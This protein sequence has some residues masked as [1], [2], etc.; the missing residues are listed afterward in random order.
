M[1]IG[2]FC[3]SCFDD[4]LLVQYSLATYIPSSHMSIKLGIETAV[5]PRSPELSVR[6]RG[7]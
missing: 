6:D 7:R 3:F 1:A 4:W 5:Q 2:N